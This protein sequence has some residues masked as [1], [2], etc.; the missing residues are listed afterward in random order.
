MNGDTSGL[1]SERSKGRVL[2]FRPQDQIDAAPIVHAL[3]RR[4]E[5]GDVVLA[6][7][8]AT[9]RV[10]GFRFTEAT[11]NHLEVYRAGWCRCC[12]HRLT[13]CECRDVQAGHRDPRELD[14]DDL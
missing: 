9:Y 1:E 3:K 8:K 7:P 4:Q 14:F 6:M 11:T 10:E 2:F 5:A 13:G 12:K